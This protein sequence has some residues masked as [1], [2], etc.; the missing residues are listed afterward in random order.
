MWL[1]KSTTVTDGYWLKLCVIV[2]TINGL[3]CENINVSLFFN[4]SCKSITVQ[5]LLGV[6]GHKIL[7]SEL[8][9]ANGS[10]K[11]PA[12]PLEITTLDALLYF[13]SE[14]ALS[15]TADS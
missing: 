8:I 14:I 11:S 12:R 6:I 5:T 9:G 1:F 3:N 2:Q 13:Q 10:I 15:I 7:A 4:N